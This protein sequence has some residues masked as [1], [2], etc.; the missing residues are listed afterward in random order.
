[1]PFSHQSINGSILQ[2]TEA[3]IPLTDLGLLRAYAIFDFFRVLQGVPVFVEDHLDRLMRSAGIMQMQ[4]PW[5]RDTV[6][7][8]ILDLIDAN[9]TK[10]AGFRIVI[11]GGY[12]E[13]GYT[14]TTPNI[15]MMLHA[16]P[17]YD[18]SDVT[19]G[20]SLISSAYV[21]DMAM[22][23]TC[24]YV[25]SLLE[26]ERMKK[27]GAV[28]ILFHWKGSI[29]ECSRSNLFFVTPEGTLVTP[30]TGMLEGI[31]RKKVL[32]LAQEMHI[33]L[34]FREVHL[35]ELPWM[36]EMIL[37]STTRGV[38]PIVRVDSQVIGNGRPGDLTMAL[39]AAFEEHV[40]AALAYVSAP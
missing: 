19:N 2:S 38:L 5:N 4:L 15:Y 6:R 37:T 23:K 20:C 28:E 14:P 34:E 1:M 24:I 9:N 39:H 13:D 29:T 36:K 27:G 33:P 40:K 7:Q 11:T 35:E 21:R 25:Q 32:A 12:S 18:P 17:I 3:R 16:L 22:V 10:D 30:A 26:L 31:T 8:W